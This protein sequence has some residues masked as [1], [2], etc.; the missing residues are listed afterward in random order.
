MDCQMPIM[1][2]YEATRVW[3]EQETK[4]RIPIVALTANASPENEENCITA[5]MDSVLSKPFRRQQLEMI[6]SAWLV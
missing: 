2:G 1:D 6:L 5:G 3:R 4:R